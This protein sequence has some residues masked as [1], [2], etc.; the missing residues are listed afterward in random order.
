LTGLQQAET[1]EAF[2]FDQRH[3]NAEQRELKQLIHGFPLS[4]GLKV[5][6]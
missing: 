3:G 1:C 6:R 5:S 2:V 4:P